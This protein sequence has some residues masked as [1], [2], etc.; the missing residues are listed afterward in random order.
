MIVFRNTGRKNYSIEALNIQLQ[1]A[2]LAWSWIVNT[3]GQ[4]GCNMPCDL[5]MEHLNR[6]L[7]T[8]LRHKLIFN[9]ILLYVQ[10]SQLGQYIEFVRHLKIYLE[11]AVIVIHIQHFKRIL[12]L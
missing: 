1:T 10:P 11:I 2:Q 8:I 4:L 7:K 12:I 3:Q 9:L 5:Y 6:R